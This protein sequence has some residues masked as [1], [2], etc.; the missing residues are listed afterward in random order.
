MISDIGCTNLVPDA[1]DEHDA[2]VTYATL[3]TSSKHKMT[4]ERAQVWDDRVRAGCLD[5]VAWRDVQ[6]TVKQE[7]GVQ[8]LEAECRQFPPQTDEAT[9]M[10]KQMCR[11]FAKSTGRSKDDFV[12]ET[13]SMWLK[14]GVLKNAGEKGMVFLPDWMAMG[15]QDLLTRHKQTTAKVISCLFSV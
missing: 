3:Y 5:F 14:T 7:P 2:L 9:R 1:I 10:Q 4:L 12:G 6:I 11:I 8:N 15:K 13:A